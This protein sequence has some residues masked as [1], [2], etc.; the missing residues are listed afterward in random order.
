MVQGR[1]AWEKQPG[2]APVLLVCLSVTAFQMLPL[3]SALAEE[4][5]CSGLGCLF[6][7]DAPSIPPAAPAGSAAA[8]SAARETNAQALKEGRADT[9]AQE[10][11]GS[12]TASVKPTSVKAA[13]VRP[14]VTI[15]A[16]ASEVDRLKR[17]AVAMPRERIRIVAPDAPADFT[18][19]KGFGDAGRG[20]TRLF[21]EALHIVA[22]PG[23]RTMGDLNGKVVAYAGG[24]DTETAAR[25]AFAAAHV[26]V[27]TTILDLPNALD[28]LSTGDLDAVVVLAPP[29]VAQFAALRTSGLHLVPWPDGVALPTGANA[30]SIDANRYANLVASGE[31]VRA[32]AV[33]AVLDLSVKGA[34]TPAA[35]TFLATL[36]QHAAA[37]A[38]RGFDLR[39]ADLDRGAGG[40]V[41]SAAGR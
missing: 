2:L 18:L 7:N 33:D 8:D 5:G 4:S 11:A 6:S 19:V 20:G 27:R 17:L 41:A 34:K 30:V 22:G 13:P 38:R 10:G 36:S 16:E 28:G 39:K 3:R 40:R 26:A 12:T 1:A 29:P 35:R 24:R 23:I 25:Q 15:A 37:L 9:L 32:V 21:T 31:S 14:V